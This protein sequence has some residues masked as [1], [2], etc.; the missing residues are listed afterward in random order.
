MWKIEFY[1]LPGIWIPVFSVIEGLWL[2]LG[3]SSI[4]LFPASFNV[5]MND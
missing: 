2:V 4:K 1:I 5:K 3:G